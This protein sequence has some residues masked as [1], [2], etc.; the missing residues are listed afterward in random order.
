MAYHSYLVSS[1]GETATL[2]KDILDLE[3]SIH[4]HKKIVQFQTVPSQY[5]PKNLAFINHP[6]QSTINESFLRKYK[7]LFLQHL[8]TV[9]EVN[10]VTLELKKAR[11]HVSQQQQQATQ[12]T[13]PPL[14]PMTTTQPN[15]KTATYSEQQV[16]GGKR[17]QPSP[18]PQQNKRQKTMDHFLVRGPKKDPKI[19]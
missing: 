17:K 4:Q 11:L 19:T 1:A 6:T 14:K 16:T 2:R 15:K 9:I 10:T 18:N 7:E 3:K 13:P 5:L 12:S 8:A